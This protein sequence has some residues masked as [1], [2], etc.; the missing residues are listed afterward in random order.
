M[1]KA[2]ILREALPYIQAFRGTTVVIKYGG[3]AM[4]DPHLQDSFAGDVTLLSMVGINPV[5]V[6]GGGPQI[7]A[8]LDKEGLQSTWIEGLRV[9]D[10]ATIRVV[11]RVLVGEINPDIVRLLGGHGAPAVGVTGLDA[12]LFTARS[13]DERLGFV[14]EVESVNVGL[15]NA[16]VEDGLVPVIAPLARGPGDAVY[17][18]NADTAAAALARSMRA[19]KL[20]YLTDVEGVRADPADANTLISEMKLERLRELLASG[21]IEGGM[22]PKLKSIAEALTGG[23][24]HAHV[25]DGRIE[26][27]VLLEI[28]TPEGIGTKI[29]P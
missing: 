22:I 29:V 3:S 14:G 10:A 28:F 17:N 1:A 21:A 23:V 27:T 25:L 9:T 2:R 11:Q 4:D 7:S 18:L 20:I 6:H 16:M 19:Q 15:I 8:A 24:R 5:I 12:G 26:H 13:V